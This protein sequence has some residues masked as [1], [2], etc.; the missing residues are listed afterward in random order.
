[1]TINVLCKACGFKLEIPGEFAGKRAKC[2]NCGELFRVP[3]ASTGGAVAAMKPLGHA[4]AEEMFLELRRRGGAGILAM[5]DLSQY[6]LRSLADLLDAGEHASLGLTVLATERLTAEQQERLLAVLA[7]GVHRAAN[8]KEAAEHDAYY[9]PFDFKGDPLG[10]T[11]AEFKQKHAREVPGHPHPAPFCSDQTG[12]FRVAELMTEP[13]YKSAGI[14]HA[15]LEYPSENRPPSIAGV[16][17][18]I[19]IYQFLDG[20]LYQIS[21]WFPAGGFPQVSGALRR[22]YGP[23]SEQSQDS[24]RLV[25]TRMASTLELCNGRISPAEPASMRIC[26]DDLLREATARKPDVGGDI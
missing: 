9:E 4:T 21:A 24:S 16:E 3:A 14:V 10:M 26:Y 23:P 25:W 7:D 8:P 13:W 5:I 1:M 20:R 15:R 6:G 19:L 17:T 11:L 12:A 22:K 2:G 18:E